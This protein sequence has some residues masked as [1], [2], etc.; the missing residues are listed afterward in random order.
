MSEL[1]H[2]HFAKIEAPSIVTTIASRLQ[3]HPS[4]ASRSGIVFKI[5]LRSARFLFGIYQKIL[6]NPLLLK[7][8]YLDFEFM[9]FFNL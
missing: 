6:C 2:I 9:D 3:P 4:C 8:E 5:S 1:K 7:G